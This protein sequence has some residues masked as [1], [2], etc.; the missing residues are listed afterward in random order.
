M[1][2]TVDHPQRRGRAPSHCRATWSTIHSDGSG[3][4]DVRSVACGSAGMR[5]F[6]S[7]ASEQRPV[8]EA[9]AFTL[10]GRGHVTFLDKEDLPPGSSYDQQ[11]ARAVAASDLLL[12]LISP[13]SVTPGRYTLSE[14]AFARKKWRSGRDH[15]LPVLVKATPREAIP[16]YLGSVQFLTPEGNVAAEVAAVVDDMVPIAKPQHVI[17]AAAALGAISGALSVI[18]TDPLSAWVSSLQPLPDPLPWFGQWLGCL[19]YPAPYAFSLALFIVLSKWD[20][21]ALSHRLLVFPVVCVAWVAAY[22]LANFIVVV[23]DGQQLDVL[24]EVVLV[25]RAAQCV[26]DFSSTATSPGATALSPENKTLVCAQID[27][28]RDQIKPLI[29]RLNYLIVSFAGMSAGLIGGVVT[30][31]GLSL[32]SGRFRRLDA[33]VL[34]AFVGAAAG[35]LLAP[36]FQSAL[37]AG[38]DLRKGSMLLFAVWQS[39]VAAAIGFQFTRPPPLVEV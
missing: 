8:A 33:I 10:R 25:P 2:W 3:A 5:I 22:D 37:N 12:F 17:P 4:G 36:S 26:D 18:N 38:A 13:E 20:R 24:H 35:I 1:V 6:L 32:L 9:I 23:G 39:A 30:A 28:Y 31:L 11:I 34:V 7:Y 21:L 15:V 19:L 27:I 14:L 29:E 16:A